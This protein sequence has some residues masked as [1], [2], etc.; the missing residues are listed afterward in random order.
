MRWD[1]RFS[2]QWFNFNST[3]RRFQTT[4]K[5]SKVFF[6]IN[7]RLS[8]CYIDSSKFRLQSDIDSLIHVDSIE[9]I[10]L[11]RFEVSFNIFISKF[12][13][14]GAFTY[15][16]TLWRAR[17]GRGGVERFWWSVLRFVILSSSSEE[18]WLQP[19][20]FRLA[21]RKPTEDHNR[22]SSVVLVVILFWVWNS[23]ENAATTQI[24][25]LKFW[26]S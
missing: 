14:M 12:S 16:V 8:A 22:I 1:P 19:W 17:E 21:R 10:Q 15:D 6:E 13:N 20:T 4:R 3:L 23:P 9:I 24:L 2:I 26:N 7:W 25:F 18:T 5:V 11:F